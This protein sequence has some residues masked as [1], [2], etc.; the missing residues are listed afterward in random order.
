ML[1]PRFDSVKMDLFENRR[2]VTLERAILYTESWKGSEG[3]SAVIRRAKALE[4]ILTKS[5]VV[6]GKR[7]LLVGG[8]S[9]KPRS[10]VVSPEMSPYWIHDELDSLA[11]RPQDQ[12]DISDHDKFQYREYLYSYWKGKSLK[13]EVESRIPEDINKLRK[14]NIVKLNQ[15]DKGQGHI[16]PNF[17]GLLSKGLGAA[18]E[19]IEAKRAEHKHNDFLRAASI[20]V[21]AVQAYV[22]RLYDAVLEH[23]QTATEERLEEVER[24][25]TILAHIKTKAPVQFDEAVQLFWI[26]NVVLQQESN[27]SSISPGR[28]DQYMYPFYEASLKDGVSES[29]MDDVLRDLMLKFNTIIAIRSEESARFFAGFPIGFNI[30]LG[31]VDR[32]GKD[33]TNRLSY[34]MLDVFSEIRLPQPNMGIRIHEKTP[35]AFLIKTAEV[36]RL[37]TG[38]PQVFNDEV[39]VPAYLNRGVSLEDA[40]NYAV[41]GCVEVS[42]PGKTYGLHDIALFNLLRLME[43]TLK[44]EH[45][46]LNTFEAL[47]ERIYERIDHDVDMMVKGSNIIDKAHGDLAPTPFLSVMIDGCV[48]RGVDVT[49][50]GAH[51]NFSG[52][53]GIGIANLADSLHV[54]RKLVFEDREMTLTELVEIL[55]SNFEGNEVLRQRLIHKFDKYGNDIDHVDELGRNVLAHYCDAVEKHRNIR[56]G[57]FSPGSYTVSAHIPLGEAVGA[58]PDGR[59]AKEQLADG[60]LSPMVGRDQKGPTASLK[61]VS[62]LDHIRLSNGSLLNV[63]F[64]PEALEDEIGIRKLVAYLKAFMRLKIQHVQ[65]NV[66]SVDMLRDAQQ[67]PERY[68]NLVVRV[69]GY[70]AMFT[71]LNKSIQDDIIMR[72]EHAL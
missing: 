5:K 48:D 8:R 18:L 56:S 59:L 39:I 28:F 34:K 31:G 54:I 19:E 1:D 33:A 9:E 69:A 24:L 27:A 7:D 67:N 44:E 49:N 15:T 16:I 17:E 72:R 13:D 43:V 65:F 71:E 37:G 58:T 55:D 12:F 29:Y 45:Q 40:R 60:G 21:R 70:S 53:Q 63:K 4:E 50:G 6:I 62:K 42:I 10:G 57:M 61:S 30:V 68:R 25:L 3:E 66:V 20:S 36:I 41:V 47:M 32:Y 64:S 22:Q 26:L 52:V 38:M 11:T 51:Y 2:E 14:S 35:E 23:K 46:R